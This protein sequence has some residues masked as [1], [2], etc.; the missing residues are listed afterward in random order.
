[1]LGKRL[2]FRGPLRDDQAGFGDADARY[3]ASMIRYAV[4][5]ATGCSIYAMLAMF[6]HLNAGLC[7]LGAAVI[8]AAVL[9][10]R[11]HRPIRWGT[12]AGAVTI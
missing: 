12:A 1:M 3:N 9:D 8:V 6:G 7:V 11:D 10:H 5:L 2:S 4:I